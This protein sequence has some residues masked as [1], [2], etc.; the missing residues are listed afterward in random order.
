MLPC[1]RPICVACARPMRGRHGQDTIVTG[2]AVIS[3]RWYT[4]PAGH[5]REQHNCA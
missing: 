2:V 4:L 1:E 5:S 3:G